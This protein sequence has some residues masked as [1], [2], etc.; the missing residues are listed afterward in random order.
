[1]GMSV[2]DATLADMKAVDIRAAIT[3]IFT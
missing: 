2:V 1:M 3:A